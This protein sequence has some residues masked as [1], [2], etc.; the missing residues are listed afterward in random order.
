MQGSF[1]T[2]DFFAALDAQRQAQNVTWKKV[3]EKAGVSASTLTRIA[4]GRRPDVDT[5]ARLCRWAGL[6]ADDFFAPADQDR[7]PPKVE[8]FTQMV[9]SLRADRNLSDDGK[10]AIEAMIRAAYE[11]F[12][13]RQ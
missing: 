12:R 10:K 6:S 3:A 2:E 5:L 8:P 9:A 7:P 13:T 1:L 4:Q 11:Q